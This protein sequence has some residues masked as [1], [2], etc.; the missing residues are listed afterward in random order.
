[1]EGAM[2]SDDALRG[3][4]SQP[5]CGAVAAGSVAPW[6]LVALEIVGLL[7]LL[8][9]LAL[10][11]AL[12]LGAE[13]FS[14]SVMRPSPV[15]QNGVI[16]GSFPA[17]E[18]RYYFVADVQPGDLMTQMS[19]SGR[20]GAGKEVELE[21]LDASAKVRDRYWV[22][23]SEASA[24]STRGFPIDASGRQVFRLRVK[25][26]ETGRFC[27]EMGGKA[28]PTSGSAGCPAPPAG[29]AAAPAVRTSRAGNIEI[30]EGKCEQRLRIGSD[31]FFD[32]DSASIRSDAEPTL[33]EISSRLAQSQQPV[34]IEG[35]TDGKGEDVYNQRLSEE[36]ASSVKSYLAAHGTPASRLTIVGWGERKPV[37]PNAK[38]DGGDDPAG[39]QKNRRVEIVINTCA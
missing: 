21:L 3:V 29:E 2:R 8:G 27:L 24:Q 32:F 22:H 38:P 1:M 13:A 12:A 26:P 30:V 18:A 31:L 35:H 14:T 39:R 17:G 15:P 11:P 34:A 23:G 33:S 20:E 7:L 28:L 19:F 4:G 10:I 9:A 25:G 16:A 6:L 5:V 37:A 36:R